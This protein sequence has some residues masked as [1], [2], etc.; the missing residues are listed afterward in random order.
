MEKPQ[1]VA[2]VGKGGVGKTLVTALLAK[3][4]SEEYDFKLLLIDADPTHPHLSKMV[5]LVPSKSIESIRSEVI[6][7]TLLKKKEIKEI[8][9][10]IDFEVYNAIAE[11]K[12]FSL[13]SI[14]Q[15][16]DP[17]CF[18]P[19]N[20]LLKKVIKSI[21]RDFEIVLIDCEAGL[22]QIN[23]Q[24][25]ENIDFLLIITDISLRSVDTADSIRKSADKFTHYR[26][27]GV[28]INKVEGDI[29]KIIEKLSSY[30]LPIVGK[31]PRDEELIQMELQGLPIID[32][33]KNNM[34]FITMKIITEKLMG[35]IL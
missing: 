30:N 31:I 5:K 34:S 6:E 10:N 7:K 1:I 28:I 13:L 32:V 35:L 9:E 22:E 8:A 29:S 24:V 11:N 14:G 27:R 16:E 23:R 15:P 33:N 26:D 3:I 17:G 12:F 19:T 18:C 20:S 4:I 25:I 2:V 21:S